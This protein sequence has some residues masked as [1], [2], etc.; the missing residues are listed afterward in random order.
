[1]VVDPGTVVVVGGVVVGGGGVV[2]GGG[3][4]VVGGVVV[5]GVGCAH[6]NTMSTPPLETVPPSSR[7]IVIVG[8]S[9]NVPVMDVVAPE[10]ASQLRIAALELPLVRKKLLLSCSEAL[11]P[12]AAVPEQLN[13]IIF[14]GTVSV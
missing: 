12:V 7:S 14:S 3:G 4:V 8:P 13:P 6:V 5:G 1:V 9:T 2:V 10:T 11:L